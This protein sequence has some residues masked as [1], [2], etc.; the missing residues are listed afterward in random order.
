MYNWA[1][2]TFLD[3]LLAKARSGYFKGKPK[4]LAESQSMFDHGA[5]RFGFSREERRETTDELRKY[6]VRIDGDGRWLA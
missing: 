3:D 6:G 5:K 1:F 2:Y 4:E